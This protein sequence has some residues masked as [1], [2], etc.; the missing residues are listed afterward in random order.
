[1]VTVTVTRRVLVAVGAAISLWMLAVFH[2]G[3]APHRVHVDVAYR[4]RK[5]AGLTPAEEQLTS[6]TMERGPADV[7]ESDVVEG[8]AI[9]ED[10]LLRKISDDVLLQ[11]IADV[12]EFS[13]FGLNDETIPVVYFYTDQT[14]EGLP[15]DHYQWKTMRT[16]IRHGNQVLFIT[17]SKSSPPSDLVGRFEK[18]EMKGLRSAELDQFINTYKSY[19]QKEPWESFNF[20]RFFYLAE[21]MRQRQLEWVFFAD[22]DVA[23]LKTLNKRDLLVPGCESFI[24]MGHSKWRTYWYTYIWSFFA[25]SAILS[26]PVLDDFLHFVL[27]SYNST[28]VVKKVL[29]KKFKEKP[30][31]CDM[32]LWYLYA[33]AADDV[34]AD[35]AR[36]KSKRVM[37]PPVKSRHIC[38][39]DLLGF[40][41]ALGYRKT[42]FALDF[43]TF[44]AK[45]NGRPM[46]SI[47]FQSVTGK[48]AMEKSY[49]SPLFAPISE[50]E[51]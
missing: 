24:D 6:D 19:G 21:L 38:N 11:G 50:R 20:R 40:D 32:T 14:G 25:G 12:P 37:L 26:R 47:H 17:N 36:A 39:T 34:V 46:N 22:S 23:V 8:R 48:N 33:V 45:V 18:V 28:D 44:T 30:W 27:D 29:K 51:N 2:G 31:V 1:M 4:L 10:I 42:G 16:A 13:A 9:G 3:V 43:E 41:H 5:F 49:F 15:Q 7:E 35:S